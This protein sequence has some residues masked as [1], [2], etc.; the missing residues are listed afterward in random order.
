M[1]LQKDSHTSVAIV[2]NEMCTFNECGMPIMC[3]HVIA[4]KETKIY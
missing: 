3:V 4:E 1:T 2:Y